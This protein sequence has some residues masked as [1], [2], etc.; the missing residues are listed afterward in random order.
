[1]RFYQ[2]QHRFYCGALLHA[3]TMY[4]SVLFLSRGSGAQRLAHG[5]SRRKPWDREPRL[6]QSRGS[7]VRGALAET[8]SSSSHGRTFLPPRWGLKA[9]ASAA[10]PANVFGAASA[11]TLLL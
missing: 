7:G 3:R 1:M 6:G 9:M 5:V 11:R 4:L 2:Q 10:D 8:S